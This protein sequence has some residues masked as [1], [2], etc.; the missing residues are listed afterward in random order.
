MTKG[1]QKELPEEQGVSKV[2]LAGCCWLESLF[3]L[4]LVSLTVQ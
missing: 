4:S 2:G 3:H 1:R